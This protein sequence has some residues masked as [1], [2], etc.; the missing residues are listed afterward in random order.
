MLALLPLL[1]VE[2]HSTPFALHAAA[3]AGEQEP[4]V[5]VFDPQLGEPATTGVFAEET[6]LLLVELHSTPFALQAACSAGVQGADFVA[7]D[8]QVAGQPVAAVFVDEA[9]FTPFEAQVDA[10][11]GEQ[12]LFAVLFAAALTSTL[13]VVSFF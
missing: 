7:C 10:Q 3:S 11:A 1:L 5:V 4:D 8:A 6:L 13:A 2:L 9:L 12:P